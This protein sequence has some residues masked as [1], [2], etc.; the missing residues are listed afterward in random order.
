MVDS[1]REALRGCKW[2]GAAPS[3]GGVTPRGRVLTFAAFIGYWVIIVPYNAG[4]HL[5]I[6]KNT[7]VFFGVIRKK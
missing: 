5:N 2:S 4:H 7:L 1:E 3:P 6:N